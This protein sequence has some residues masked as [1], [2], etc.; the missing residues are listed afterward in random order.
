[1]RTPLCNNSFCTEPASTLEPRHLCKACS[2]DP[3]LNGPTIVAC[4]PI[5]KRP[6]N[7]EK[8]SGHHQGT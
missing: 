2:K 6:P 5:P 1:V 4:R 3:A 8:P 7:K